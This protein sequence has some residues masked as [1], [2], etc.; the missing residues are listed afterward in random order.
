ML[1]WSAS[2]F[3]RYRNK[4][5]RFT[6]RQPRALLGSRRERLRTF[7]SM[8]SRVRT[9]R[10]RPVL[11]SYWPGLGS[12]IHWV[13]FPLPRGPVSLLAVVVF[14]FTTRFECQ[15]SSAVFSGLASNRTGLIKLSFEFEGIWIF[16][17]GGTLVW[18]EK[19]EWKLVNYVKYLITILICAILIK[20]I[21]FLFLMRQIYATNF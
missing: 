5:W 20:I 1:F 19:G 14:M 17:E 15:P 10:V 2:R 11:L 9:L 8:Q 21:N 7:P 4:L 3:E 18:R 13:S 16:W 12:R 6:K